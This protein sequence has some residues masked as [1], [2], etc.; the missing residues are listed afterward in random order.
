MARIAVRP[1]RTRAELSRFID[2]AW[3]IYRDDPLWVPPLRA[4]Q[5]RL[6]TPGRHPFWGF[7]E[8]ELFLAWRGDTA[9][10]RIAAILDRSSNRFQQV[11]MGVWGFFE[12]RN[13]PEAAVALFRAAET[14]ARERDLAFMRGP[15]SPSPNYEIGLLVTGFD[16]APV[17]MMTYNPPYYAELVALCGYHKEKD[18]LA[19]RY[20]LSRE[21]PQYALDLAARIAER[22]EFRVR[23]ARGGK[24]FTE[25]LLELNR[26][27]GE[28]WSDNWGFVPMSEA[29]IRDTARQLRSI[30]DLDLAFFVHRGDEAVGICLLVP[31]A[32]FLLQRFN[33]S[34]GPL[35]LLKLLL[36]RSKIAGLRGMLFG[37][38]REYR[39]AGLPFFALSHLRG[40]LA[41]KPQYRWIE[42]GWNLEDNPAINLLYEEGGLLPQKRYRIFR[43]DLG[44]ASA[45]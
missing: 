20:D 8:R 32:N 27:Y 40:V 10:G 15:M 2:L 28:C 35:A 9:V 3:D 18:L 24:H 31:D 39:Q 26:I 7:A 11:R 4:E 16:D 12:C 38:K 29:E 44:A 6:L 5:R 19:Y 36:Y 34:L 17:L 22:G 37:V 42:M 41:R 1:V 45:A 23:Q 43:K 21:L 25:E 14:W 33:G 13:D 30:L